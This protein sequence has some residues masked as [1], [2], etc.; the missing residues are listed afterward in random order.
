MLP[1]AKDGFE[2][3]VTTETPGDA[4]NWKI[5]PGERDAVQTQFKNG[6]LL[7]SVKDRPEPEQPA[8]AQPENSKTK[9]P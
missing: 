3:R 1:S 2:V 8:L 5:P 6:A 4:L 7:L 9:K